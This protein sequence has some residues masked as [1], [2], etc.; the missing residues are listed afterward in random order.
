MCGIEF[1]VQDMG[2]MWILVDTVTDFL[3]KQG[4]K[5]SSMVLKNDFSMGLGEKRANSFGIRK[6]FMKGE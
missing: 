3:F 1:L 2:H 5:S 6:A 4:Q